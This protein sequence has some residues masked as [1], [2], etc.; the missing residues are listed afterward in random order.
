MTTRLRLNSGILQRFLEATDFDTDPIYVISASEFSFFCLGR[1]AQLSCELKP[2]GEVPESSNRYGVTTG[3][4]FFEN[5]LEDF[6]RTETAVDDNIII[7]VSEDEQQDEYARPQKI[8]EFEVENKPE[9]RIRVMGNAIQIE[10]FEVA[11]VEYEAT[12]T[13]SA[14]LFDEAVDC[15]TGGRCME[16]DS[17][18]VLLPPDHRYSW[19]ENPSVYEERPQVKITLT[20]TDIHFSGND[21]S[22]S[23]EMG[24]V[25]ETFVNLNVKNPLSVNVDLGRLFT[26]T[27]STWDAKSVTMSASPGVPFR[28]DVN[29][30]DGLVIRFD[31]PKALPKAVES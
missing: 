30:V 6:L 26:F 5:E 27:Y 7:T 20:P 21:E 23:Y 18:M 29:V 12:A 1:S 28:V 25:E 16:P 14:K 8:I 4:S 11:E 19:E 2:E 9:V 15:L 17:D 10:R 3:L 31:L 24:E 22:F 13:F